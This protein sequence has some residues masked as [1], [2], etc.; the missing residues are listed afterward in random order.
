M[1]SPPEVDER[2]ISEAE[3]GGSAIPMRMGHHVRTSAP[4]RQGPRRWASAI[5]ISAGRRA[6]TRPE[7]SNQEVIAE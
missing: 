3:I 4:R 2:Q 1:S 5:T 7:G 6:V